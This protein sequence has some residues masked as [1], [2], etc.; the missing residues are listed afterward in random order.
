MISINYE[1]NKSGA[2]PSE[3]VEHHDGDAS[4]VTPT[5]FGFIIPFHRYVIVE[6]SCCELHQPFSIHPYKKISFT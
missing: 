4:V 6:C 3:R 1:A 5:L 2:E